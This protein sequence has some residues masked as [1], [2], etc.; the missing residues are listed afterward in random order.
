[1][2]KPIAAFLQAGAAYMFFAAGMFGGDA[3]LLIV[4]AVVSGVAGL[5]LWGRASRRSQN[6][7]PQTPQA[8]PRLGRVQDAIAHLQ[9]NIAELREERDVLKTLYEARVTTPQESK[10]PVDS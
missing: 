10:A 5:A 2:E 6:A 9:D 8:D 7:L 4:P 1:M 3:T